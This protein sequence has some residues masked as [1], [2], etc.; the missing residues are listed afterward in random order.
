MKGITT[1]QSDGFAMPPAMGGGVELIPL[2]KGI[3]TCTHSSNQLTSST[4]QCWINPA[5]EGN[6]DAEIYPVYWKHDNLLVELIPLMKGI[7]TFHNSSFHIVAHNLRW[8]NPANEGNYDL[9]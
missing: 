1:Q 5:N 7:T 8:I 2:M 9:K 3:T 4:C 6:Y